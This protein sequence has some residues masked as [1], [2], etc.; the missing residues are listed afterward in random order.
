M[1][2]IPVEVAPLTKL[3]RDA[4]KTK[5]DFVKIDVQGAEYDIL[6]GLGDYLEGVLALELETQVIPIY[7]GQKTLFQIC[8]VLATKG[9][10]LRGMVPQGTFEGEIVEIEVYFA[11]ELG[12]LS[13]K[14]RERVFLWEAIVE[15]PQLPFMGDNPDLPAY[16]RLAKTL[17]ESDRW[18]AQAR[19]RVRSY[20]GR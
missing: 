9:F 8:D 14:D 19:A 11:K 15:C 18:N 5:A 17:S 1:R 2:R 6:E 12:L 4:G 16:P 20:L 13:E 7:E 3:L 10:R